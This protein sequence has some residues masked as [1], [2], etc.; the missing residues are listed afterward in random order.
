MLSGLINYVEPNWLDADENND[1]T[2]QLPLEDLAINVNLSV[3]VPVEQREGIVQQE[4]NKYVVTF[5][6]DGERTYTNLMQ[7][8][9]VV[10]TQSQTFLTTNYTEATYEDVKKGGTNE[11]FGISSIDIQYNDYYTPQVTIQFV[12][13]RGTALFAPE[14]QKHPGT[15]GY[16]DENIAGSFFRCFFIMPYPKFTLMVKGF[17]GQPVTYEL[18]CSDFRAK[19]DSKTG[20][21]NATAKLVGYTFSILGDITFNTLLTSPCSKYG[22]A[23]Y[24]E[25]QVMSQRF[26]IG[27][28]PMKKL[29]ELLNEW[30]NIAKIVREKLTQTQE[31]QALKDTVDKRTEYETVKASYINLVNILKNKC[32]H[33]DNGYQILNVPCN[34]ISGED[35]GKTT[36]CNCSV[37]YEE[38]NNFLWFGD[39]YEGSEQVIEA[40]KKFETE[41]NNL[42]LVRSKKPIVQYNVGKLRDYGKKEYGFIF[43]RTVYT[44]DNKWINI[45]S[46]WNNANFKEINKQYESAWHRRGIFVR[47][48]DK[49]ASKGCFAFDNGFIDYI[50]ILINGCVSNTDSAQNE[51]EKKRKELV[52]ESF[53]IAP[54]IYNVIKTIMA[55]LETLMYEMYTCHINILDSKRTI[56]SVGIPMENYGS[57]E[58]LRPFPDVIEV[59]QD[60]NGGSDNIQKW[61]GDVAK[62]IDQVEEINLINGLLEGLKDIAKSITDYEVEV[63]ENTSTSGATETRTG[64]PPLI[65]HDIYCSK[66]WSDVNINNEKSISAAIILRA[67]SVL[68]LYYEWGDDDA[69]TEPMGAQDAKLWKNSFPEMGT[70]IKT[71]I[72]N[73]TYDKERIIKDCSEYFYNSQPLIEKINVSNTYDEWRIGIGKDKPNRLIPIQ[74]IDTTLNS[75]ML[76]EMFLGDTQNEE[77]YCRCEFDKVLQ[78]PNSFKIDKDVKK[79]VE[80]G[81]SH[82]IDKLKDRVGI[83]NFNDTYMDWIDYNGQDSKLIAKKF[84]SNEV[85]IDYEPVKG[86]GLFGKTKE[87][88]KNLNG[89][90]VFG[91]GYWTSGDGYGKWCDKSWT[92]GKLRCKDSDGDIELIERPSGSFNECFADADYESRIGEYTIPMFRGIVVDVD[93]GKIKS[94]PGQ[95]LFAQPIYYKWG[96]TGENA[97]YRQAYLFLKTFETVHYDQSIFLWEWGSDVQCEGFDFEDIIEKNFMNETWDKDKKAICMMPYIVL[98][99]LGASFYLETE[100]GKKLMSLGDK[101]LNADIKIIA[102]K[103]LDYNLCPQTKEVIIQEFKN[104]ADGTFRNKIHSKYALNI[105]DGSTLEDIIHYVNKEYDIKKDGKFVEVKEDEKRASIPKTFASWFDDVFFEQYVSFITGNDVAEIGETIY[106]NA[107]LCSA[108]RLCNRDTANLDEIMKELY[109]P[110]VMVMG[111]QFIQYDG[112]KQTYPELLVRRDRLEDYLDGFI[113]ELKNQYERPVSDSTNTM[114]KVESDASK[115]IKHSLYRYLKTVYDKWLCGNLYEPK[116]G[117][118][119]GHWTLENFFEP[120]FHFIDTFYNY[121]G[122]VLIDIDDFLARMVQSTTQSEYT[123]IQFISQICMVNNMQIQ[124]IQNFLDYNNEKMMKDMF[125][126]IPNIKCQTPEPEEIY[127]DFVF[128]KQNE[129]SKHLEMK[130]TDGKDKNDGFMIYE[131]IDDCELPVP[132]A[133]KTNMRRP[134][135]MGGGDWLSKFDDVG[136]YRHKIP[137]FG[138]AYGYQYQSYFTDIQI[139]MDNPI[140]TEQSIKAEMNILMVNHNKGGGTEQEEKSDNTK[141]SVGKQDL[142]SVYMNNSYSCEVTML[143][144]PW[145][146]PLMYFCLLNVPMFRGCYLIHKVSH[147]IKPGDMKTKFT[148]TRICRN[149]SAIADSIDITAN[150]TVSNEDQEATLIEKK[151]ELANV[152][153]DCEYKKFYPQYEKSD[154]GSIDIEELKNTKVE[155]FTVEGEWNEWFKE[156]YKGSTVWDALVSNLYGEYGNGTDLDQQLVSTV[157]YNRIMKGGGVHNTGLSKNVCTYMQFNGF[158]FMDQVGHSDIKARKEYNNGKMWD[159]CA[160]NLEYIFTNSPSILVGTQVA[161]T[162]STVI[163]KDGVMT[164]NI[165]QSKNLTLEDVQTAYF[166]VN[167]DWYAQ[168]KQ[169]GGG[170]R[171]YDYLFHHNHHLFSTKNVGKCWEAE[172]PKPKE[173]ETPITTLDKLNDIIKSIEETCISSPELGLKKIVKHTIEGDANNVIISPLDELKSDKSNSKLYDVVLNTYSKYLTHIYWLTKDSNSS[174]NECYGVL[175]GMADNNDGKK[176][177]GVFYPNDGNINTTQGYTAVADNITKEEPQL[178]EGTKD[179]N[180]VAKCTKDD[181]PLDTKGGING[182][183]N[184]QYYTTLGKYYGEITDSNI[185]EFH[186][187]KNYTNSNLYDKENHKELINELLNANKATSCDGLTNKPLESSSNEVCGTKEE[188]GKLLGGT[189]QLSKRFGLAELT[190]SSTAKANG[191]D[192]MPTLEALDELKKTAAF[193][194][195]YMDAFEA[196]MSGHTVQFVLN[197][198]YRCPAVNT[199]VG[200]SK[201]SQHMKG[202]AMDIDVIIDKRVGNAEFFN[203]VKKRGHGDFGQLI[204]EFGTSKQPSWVHISIPSGNKKNQVLYATKVEGKTKYLGSPWWTS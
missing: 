88:T 144:C 79:F 204:W 48:D 100:E 89:T 199:L 76:E 112:K 195:G 95:S 118:L 143:G 148:G 30:T 74:Q 4:N 36:S 155:D 197:S 42:K 137:C 116:E 202:Q 16:V 54:T 141:V 185:N 91:S 150:E 126:P 104:W 174:K 3:E 15:A 50:D 171:E 164:S 183:L 94:A 193:I 27:G 189:M 24:W 102:E 190:A 6:S 14:E 28:K 23:N 139:G 132:I 108:F 26:Y 106:G 34:T 142:Y 140:A 97:H 40:Y 96:G 119:W 111:N 2:H 21:F 19:F 167:A 71:M 169:N 80:I 85:I 123:L 131:G 75:T 93:N 103:S 83:S 128:I 101:Q 153:N 136:K 10:S 81:Q 184:K 178:C 152:D 161:P 105:K 147:S 180:G 22:G 59:V 179:A 186:D 115:D 39:N 41:F 49:Y 177:I 170:H 124:C 175:I 114:P 84:T 78:N 113:N 9:K 86:S 98:L 56:G 188:M 45:P 69:I 58:P 145:V 65:V 51:L 18:T 73:G 192:N 90:T 176:N 62:N 92:F 203:F 67:M 172:S 66:I 201:T 31:A 63:K 121:S 200:G 163:Y 60:E 25:E 117:Y 133:S 134:S 151:S 46:A 61:I 57:D 5:M 32:P 182:I 127:C 33:K 166:Y 77:N 158:K 173:G 29:H 87:E 109:S 38:G 198:S 64:F 156:T 37:L 7:G 129:P 146:Q 17:F 157:I 72:H 107:G 52:L 168:P 154:G 35:S 191:Y 20:N 11:M 82:T 130:G 47:E 196:E 55:H 70:T 44:G 110:C 159:R 160:K 53:D 68:G 165:T 194:E 120:H 8:S 122:Q 138:V 162:K 125:R 13:I 135:W 43:T 99:Y 149:S 12:D 181:K 187:V 1:V